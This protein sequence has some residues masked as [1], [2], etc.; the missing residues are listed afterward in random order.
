MVGAR[1][2]LSL[3]IAGLVLVLAM[4]GH[5]LMSAPEA[6]AIPCTLSDDETTFVALLAQ[7]N[8]GPAVGSTYCDLAYGGHAVAYDVRHGVPPTTEAI[9]VYKNTNL[10]M[11]QAIWYVAAAVVVFA[12][13]MV[14]PSGGSG[15]SVA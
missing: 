12:P 9:T 7:K 14:P 2:P 5:L 6:S 11:D 10:S 4:L 15:G 13:E 8:I 1:R 3:W